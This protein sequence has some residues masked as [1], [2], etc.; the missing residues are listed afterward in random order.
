MSLKKTTEL[1]YSSIRYPGPNTTMSK[2]WS[3]RISEYIKKSDNFYFLDA[4]CG[5]CRH[6]AGILDDYKNSYGV[7]IDLSNPSL[8]A[9]EKF[10]NS[11]NFQGRF[12]LHK[13][14]FSQKL[15]F[16]KKFDVIFAIGCIH[17]S[18]DY[19]KSFRN[20]CA[21][22]KKGGLLCGM[23]YSERGH[24][25]RYE[26]KEMLHLLTKDPKVMM[27]L[28]P[29]F[30]KKLMDHTINELIQKIKNYCYQAKLKLKGKSTYYG[31][32]AQE[33][34]TKPV[35]FLDT[36][37][38]PI[39]YGLNTKDF[40]RICNANNLEV[41]KLAGYEKY[42]AKNIDNSLAKILDHM[43]L[44]DQIRFNELFDQYPKSLSFILK[45]K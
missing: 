44:W 11:F 41:L 23:I 21:N 39:D 43:K 31:Y 8:K 34:I 22:L 19:E 15:K 29:H 24:Q 35:F 37:C 2:Q 38:A 10:L 12:E 36:F 7:G 9:G 42:K 27:D 5:S 33:N 13:K 25:R 1:F 20:L 32:A 28:Y 14:S 18:K 30:K 3:E 6:L 17:H 26:I 16:K 45:K 40:Q 4:G